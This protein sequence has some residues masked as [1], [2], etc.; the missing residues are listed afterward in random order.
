[1]TLHDLDWPQAAEKQQRVIAAAQEAITRVG[2]HADPRWM[3][4]A[5]RAT[6]HIA[7]TVH[8][9]TSD[10]IWD[11]LE[12]WYPHVRTHD[13]RAMGAVLTWAVRNHLAVLQSC[14]TCGTRKVTTPSR[15]LTSH[16]TDTAL[17][18]SLVAGQV[19][20]VAS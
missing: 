15:R 2:E 7:T 18:L 17:Y 14:T 3:I 11:E 9:F 16:G 5:R 1:M 10:D 4:T 13:N 12:F 20:G 19:V 6:V 8:T